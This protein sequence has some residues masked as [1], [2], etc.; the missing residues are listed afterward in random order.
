MLSLCPGAEQQTSTPPRK[1]RRSG[2]CS[3]NYC[4]YA[5]IAKVDSD[6]SR[7]EALQQSHPQGA[8]NLLSSTDA[9]ASASGSGARAKMRAQPFS[10]CHLQL[11]HCLFDEGN[12]RHHP[13]DLRPEHHQPEHK[14]PEHNRPEHDLPEHNLPEHNLPGHNLPGHNPPGRPGQLIPRPRTSRRDSR[15]ST[16]G[17]LDQGHVEGSTPNRLQHDGDPAHPRQRQPRLSRRHRLRHLLRHHDRPLQGRTFTASQQRRP[18]SSFPN[19]SPSTRW[20]GTPSRSRPSRCKMT[21]NGMWKHSARVPSSASLGA[22]CL[23][24]T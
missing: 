15:S 7:L 6:S 22:S 11:G 9:E 4:S 1:K 24:T 20:T 12:L 3:S 19:S 8:Q 13:G 23:S 16:R 14:H 5:K 18:P 10:A 2:L 17:A 21:C